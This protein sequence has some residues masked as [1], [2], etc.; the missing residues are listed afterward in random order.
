[1]PPDNNPHQASAFGTT[2]DEKERLAGGAS[3]VSADIKALKADIARLSETVAAI[4]AAR[5]ADAASRLGKGV[6][7]VTDGV[8]ATASNVYDAGSDIASSARQHAASFADDI[9][10]TVRR[11]PLGTL[12]ATLGLGMILG[13]MSR[14]R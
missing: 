8:G 9:E 12:I 3:D 5:G 11:N 7:S 1:M 14:S 6:R 4:A 10:A 13:M 2:S